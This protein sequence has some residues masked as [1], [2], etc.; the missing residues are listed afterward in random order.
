MVVRRIVGIVSASTFVLIAAACGGSSAT[1]PSAPSAPA[2]PAATTRVIALSGNLAFGNVP[3]GSSLEAP[4]TIRNTGTGPLT[5]NGMT[6]PGGY[7]ASWTSG[8]VPAGGSQVSTIR[9]SPA[10]AQSYNGT[11]TVN[12][13]QTSGTNMLSVSGTGTTPTPSTVTINGIVTDGTSGGVLPNILLQIT[14]GANGGKSTRTDGAGGYTI[15]SVTPGSFTMSL[16]ATS[17]I[18]Q[19]RQVTVTSNSR[20]DFVMQRVAPA[21]S[22]APSPGPAPAPGGLWSV[23]GVGDNVFTMPSSVL[24][25]RITGV[26]TAFSRN[27]IVWLNNRLLVNELLGT[28]WGQTRYEGVLLG[29]G[30]LVQIQHSNGVAWTMTQVP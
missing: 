30:G 14:D 6:G 22:P 25:V 9:F 11:L 28:A 2:P 17:Y 18:P 21:P 13:D 24:R 27:F 10:A 15:G 8:T 5:V 16:M 26:Y 7:T 29:G 4:L 3:V 20:I 12:G 19:S 1:T 23:S